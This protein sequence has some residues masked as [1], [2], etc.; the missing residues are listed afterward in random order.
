[1]DSTGGEGSYQ[2]TE[3]ARFKSLI[4]YEIDIGILALCSKP[5]YTAE[6]DPTGKET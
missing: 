4:L 3:L 1:M 5:Q 6:T 2:N